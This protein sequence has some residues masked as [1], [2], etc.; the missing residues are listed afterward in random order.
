LYQIDLSAGTVA[1]PGRVQGPWARI[2]VGDLSAASV[3]EMGD[4]FGPE[5]VALV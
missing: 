3:A 2:A 5:F 1:A 4:A